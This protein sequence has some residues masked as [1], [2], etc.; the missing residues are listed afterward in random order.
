MP[1]SVMQI[2]LLDQGAQFFQAPFG[3][4]IDIIVLHCDYYW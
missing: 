3:E 1:P 2:V 4:L